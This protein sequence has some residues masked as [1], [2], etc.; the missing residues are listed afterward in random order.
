MNEQKTRKSQTRTK[1]TS[2]AVVNGKFRES[3]RVKS[4]LGK[5]LRENQ[6][7][8]HKWY[9]VAQEHCTHCVLV[10]MKLWFIGQE[11]KLVGTG[12]LCFSFQ[13][14][15]EFASMERDNTNDH[16]RNPTPN[17]VYFSAT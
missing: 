5:F 1:L 9:F 2:S 7:E 15:N 17:L 4:I 13:R 3:A 11:R 10:F 12:Q 16:V 8:F 14:E 6:S